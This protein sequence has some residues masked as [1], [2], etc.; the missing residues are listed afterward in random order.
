MKTTTKTIL[1]IATSGLFILFLNYSFISENEPGSNKITGTIEAI[2]GTGSLKGT[3]VFTGTAPKPTVFQ[4]E[5]DGN[6][7]G[8]GKREIQE[9][10]ADA[11]GNLKGVVVYLQAVQ[12]GKEFVKPKDGYVLNQEG[13]H[14]LPHVLVVP[15]GADVSIVNKDPVLHNIHTYQIL[16]KVRRSMFNIA[17]PEQNQKITQKVD[18][19]NS[20]IIK[21]ECDAH[22]FMHA[23][24][25]TLDNPYYA[26]TDASGNF[27]IKDIPAGKYTV[28]VWNPTLE[29][30]SKEVE[31]IDGK[32]T[33][34]LELAK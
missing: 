30:I 2:S 29:V 26:I 19:K 21:V 9:V 28:K 1:L 18:P 10:N 16:G 7:C 34:K 3:V 8:S 23:W 22:N 27:E 11:K 17:Q 24:I 6:T 20:N 14:F 13:C 31:I 4:V 25:L 15:K 5:K 33:V 12:G 32:N